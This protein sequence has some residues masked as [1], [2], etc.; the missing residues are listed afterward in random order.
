MDAKKDRFERSFCPA[1]LVRRIL[2]GPMQSMSRMIISLVARLPVR[3]SGGVSRPTEPWEIRE[4]QFLLAAPGVC[5]PLRVLGSR[6]VSHPVTRVRLCGT[7]P[8]ASLWI[9]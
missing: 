6:G 8:R 4:T 9:I 2:S 5:R 3:S 7:G 1:L